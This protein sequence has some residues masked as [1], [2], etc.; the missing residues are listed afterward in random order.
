MARTLSP[1]LVVTA[2]MV[3]MITSWDSSGRPRQFIDYLGA[4]NGR[5]QRRA[6]DVGEGRSTTCAH[7]ICIA[8]TTE[9]D[10]RSAVWWLSCSAAGR[11]GREATWTVPG[12]DHRPVAA[13]EEYLEFL[14][15]QGA[16][17]NTVKSYA[18]ALALWWQ[19]LTVFELTW[20]AVRLSEVGGFLTWLRSGDGPDV[21]SIQARPAR[22]CE[23]TISAR[24]A[25]VMSWYG[26]HELNGVELGRDLY[27]LV[28]AR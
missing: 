14:R 25:A 17:P 16:S 9:C 21:S 3:S 26:Y 10:D 22:F 24:L 1:D 23:S 13:I 5:P 7:T 18:R 20:D 4:G 12:V 6:R 19:Y 2:L 8:K 27:R 15:V 28:H 11:G